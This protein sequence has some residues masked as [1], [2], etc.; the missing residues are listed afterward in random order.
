MSEKLI[1]YL[2]LT[3]IPKNDQYISFF[4]LKEMF[5]YPEKLTLSPVE[6]QS[7]LLACPG[8][9]GQPLLQLL[10]LLQQLVHLLVVVEGLPHQLSLG[11]P[12]MFKLREEEERDGVRQAE[13]WSL[14]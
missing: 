3:L 14:H 2:M 9:L 8:L 6:F 13:D 7:Q 5:R 11:Q 1:H 12:G 4:V 10:L